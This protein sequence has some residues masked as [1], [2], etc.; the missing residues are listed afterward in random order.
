[1]VQPVAHAALLTHC[2]LL[3][4]TPDRLVPILPTSGG[5]GMRFLHCSTAA[6]PDVTCSLSVGF[7]LQMCV[8]HGCFQYPS[9]QNTLNAL[10]V[11]VGWLEEDIQCR[12]LRQWLKLP[13]AGH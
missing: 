2:P 10:L 12:Y 3:H 5:A 6:L 13:L 7:I 9:V 8:Y 1:M 11:S 4:Q